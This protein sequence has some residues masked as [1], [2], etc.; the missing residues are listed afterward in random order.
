[1]ARLWV[2]RQDPDRAKRVES[3]WADRCGDWKLTDLIARSRKERGRGYESR[4]QDDWVLR[5]DS[6]AVFLGDVPSE[7]DLV[8]LAFGQ[9]WEPLARTLRDLDRAEPPQR[10]MGPRQ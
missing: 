4:Y 5:S 2:K 9:V 8:K 3:E 10:I 7:G 6:R 1:M